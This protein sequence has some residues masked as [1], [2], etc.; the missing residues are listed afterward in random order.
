MM[1]GRRP[2]LARL[3]VFGC[4]A[5]VFVEP[6]YRK[7]LDAKAAKGVFPGYARNANA[8]VAALPNNRGG[9]RLVQ[10][11]RITFDEGQPFFKE[12]TDKFD[13]LNSGDRDDSGDY[14]S[15]DGGADG[16]AEPLVLP[17]PILACADGNGRTRDGGMMISRRCCK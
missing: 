6:R 17:G 3:R 9:M 11:R 7:K 15:D 2:N 8:Y 5:F 12:T 16:V 10:I 1:F 4:K 13:Y 14:D